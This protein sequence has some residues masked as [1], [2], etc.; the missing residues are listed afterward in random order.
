MCKAY[1]QNVLI[2]KKYFAKSLGFQR[3]HTILLNT[4]PLLDFFRF[5]KK[6]FIKIFPSFCSS[7]YY[8]LR[9]HF[10]QFLGKNLLEM[11]KRKS[12]VSLVF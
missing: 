8:Y 7:I 2:Q 11:R 6:S 3:I 5:S 12:K 4:I 9:H 1:V 10:S